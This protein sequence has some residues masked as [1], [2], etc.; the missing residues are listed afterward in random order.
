METE[1]GGRSEPRREPPGGHARLAELCR[2][3]TDPSQSLAL[4]GRGLRLVDTITSALRTGTPPQ[5]LD[6]VFDE[7]EEELLAAGHSA[8]L[9]SYRTTP[10]PPPP[11]YQ[12]LPVAGPGHPPLRVLACPRGHCGRVEAPPGDDA[13]PHPGCRVF[14]Q[15]LRTVP[16]R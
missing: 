10:T 16:L 3:L 1:T 13:A 7:L 9:G 2:R 4:G 15:P 12:R 14:D 8:G 11:G 5:E 6:D